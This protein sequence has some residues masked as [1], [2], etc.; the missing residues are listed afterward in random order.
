MGAP[1]I[2]AAIAPFWAEFE[3]AHGIPVAS[4]FYE[5]THFD[6]NEASANHLAAL[7]LAGKKRATAGLAWSFDA[8]KG[9]PP[10]A[11]DLSVI[12]DWGGNPLCVIETVSVAVV[13][14]EEVS[15]EF[16]AAEGEGNG[17]LDYW[18]TVH[19]EY[20]LR[21]CARIGRKPHAAMP[22]LCEHFEVIYR[23]P[24]LSR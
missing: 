13:P 23:G 9:R 7:V 16:A 21:E 6:D 20:F 12:T 11:G 4:R 17:S 2:P 18:R 1:P 22:V 14:F 5:A 10:K 15:A 3:A 8:E 24:V 19:W